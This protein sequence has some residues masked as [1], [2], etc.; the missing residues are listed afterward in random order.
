MAARSLL[1][2]RELDGRAVEVSVAE[3]AGEDT[4]ACACLAGSA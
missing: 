1:T 2:V 4:A 3:R